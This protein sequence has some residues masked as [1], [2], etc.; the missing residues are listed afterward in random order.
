MS[1]PIRWAMVGG[2]QGGFIGAV[3]RAAAALDGVCRLCAGALSSDPDRALSSAR[4]IGLPRDRA[5]TDWRSMLASERS[6]P[7]DQRVELVSIVTPNH[8]HHEIAHAF[9]D[10]GFHVLIDKPMTRTVEEARDLVSAVERAGVIGAVSYNY[11]GYPMVRQAAEMVRSGALG[12]VRRV[13]VEYHQGWL[14]THLEASGQ[15]QASWRT[16]PARAGAGSV[17]DIGAHA[18]HLLRFVTGLEIEALCAEANTFVPGRRVDDDAAALL[19]LRGGARATLT[20]SQVCIGEENN[21]SIRV[22]GELGSLL[23]RQESPDQLDYRRLD[24]L[25][26]TLTRGSPQLGG[27]ATQATRLPTGHPEGFIEA[28]AN[29]YKDVGRAVAASRGGRYDLNAAP[30]PTVR[31]G[32]RGVEFVA[33]MLESARVTGWVQSSP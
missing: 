30:F 25:R 33:W 26:Q 18:E 15:K 21:L 6:R 22:H 20:A 3:H 13:Y 23:W 32:L 28:F 2:G 16:D 19:R 8:T 24:G 31:D 7:A 5:Y 17:G 11:S 9:I 10:A 12:A 27:A 29:I 4:A 1:E 14:A